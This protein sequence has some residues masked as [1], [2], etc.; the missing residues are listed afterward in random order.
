[1]SWKAL[2]AVIPI[3]L[4]LTFG[5]A[6]ARTELRTVMV[7]DTVENVKQD[8]I[9]AV[10]N[11]GLV[12]DH[13]SHVGAMLKRTGKDLGATKDIYADAQT[14]QFCSAKLSRAMMEANPRNV[15][16]CPFAIFVYA[17]A[18]APDTTYVGFRSLPL[19]GSEASRA[20]LRAVN[21]LL[22]ALLLDAAGKKAN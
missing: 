13:T 12:V 15:G 3:A 19:E 17:L 18:A 5:E 22:E 1:M 8:V 6:D 7:K 16:F 21:E 14:V 2:V 11:R 20:A 9:D 4:S 10:I